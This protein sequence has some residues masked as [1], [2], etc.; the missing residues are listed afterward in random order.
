[1]PVVFRHKGFRYYF[2]SNEGD[3]REPPHVHVDKD[4]VEA[5]FWLHPEVNLAYNDGYNARVLRELREIVIANRARIEAVW[6][7]HF[8]DS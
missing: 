3:P 6:H 8:G 1:M 5:T 7:A 2:F 4:G